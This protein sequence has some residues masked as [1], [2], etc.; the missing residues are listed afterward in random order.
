MTW[1]VFLRVYRSWIPL[2]SRARSGPRYR[3]HVVNADRSPFHFSHP[4][5][6]RA[7]RTAHPPTCTK[8]DCGSEVD[9]ERLEELSALSG[10]LEH[11]PWYFSEEKECPARLDVGANRLGVG[12]AS[13]ELDVTDGPLLKEVSRS[14]TMAE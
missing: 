2:L 10:H 13:S 4:G 7:F 12:P 8:C 3:S 1:G 6:T 5:K 9:E 14:A 11:V